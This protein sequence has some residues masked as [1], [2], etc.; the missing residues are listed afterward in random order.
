[1]AISEQCKVG[2]HFAWAGINPGIKSPVSEKRGLAYA[3][4]DKRY[5]MFKDRLIARE[6]VV[7]GSL[8]FHG[9]DEKFNVPLGLRGNMS[10]NNLEVLR[11][12]LSER[13]PIKSSSLE[14]TVKSLSYLASKGDMSVVKSDWD[15]FSKL[16]HFEIPNDGAR[17]TM[18]TGLKDAFPFVYNYPPFKR[19]MGFRNSYVTAETKLVLNALGHV[20]VD[21]IPMLVSSVGSEHANKLIKN[22]YNNRRPELY[23]A[24]VQQL[25]ISGDDVY[26]GGGDF[27]SMMK[28]NVPYQHGGFAMWLS[29]ED[30]EVYKKIYKSTKPYDVPTVLN[31]SGKGFK[32]F[33]PGVVCGQV[34]PFTADEIFKDSIVPRRVP[35]EIDHNWKGD[36]YVDSDVVSRISKSLNDALPAA[37]ADEG[38]I[39][40]VPQ[41]S[42]VT[43]S[44]RLPANFKTPG[45]V[46]MLPEI[47]KL[48]TVTYLFLMF[49]LLEVQHLLETFL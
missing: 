1:M 47:P 10:T 23:S 12:V 8:I 7:D 14:S 15:T 41:S 5:H 21:S 40:G 13:I 4:A 6:G 43:V 29:A 18:I 24:P 2:L 22:L 33:E 17:S 3:D 28:E 49:P 48:T 16:S 26:L 25:H 34:L 31:S 42:A 39:E 35:P 32:V 46:N 19:S 44:N 30:P 20:N 27:G 9:K 37:F 38:K 11:S 36:P 45:V